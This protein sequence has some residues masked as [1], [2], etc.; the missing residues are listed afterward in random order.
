[1][2]KF[3]DQNQNAPFFYVVSLPDPHDPNLVRAPYNTMYKNISFTLPESFHYKKVKS[4]PKWRSSDPKIPDEQHILKILPSYYGMVKCIDDN[5]GRLLTQLE[6]LKLL[7]NTI[8][9]FSSDHGDMLGEHRRKNKG[10]PFEGS[11]KIPFLIHYPNGIAPG[12]VVR[13]AANATDWMETIL[14]L[15]GV[16]N[17]P[18][19]AGR[20]LIPLIK[21]PN[22]NVWDDITFL[23][24]GGW[25]AAFDSQYKLVLDTGKSTS[26]WLLDLKADPNESMN[27]I[28]SPQHKKVVRHLAKKL[29][30][31]IND[32]NDPHK[33]NTSIM[34]K[35]E[36]LIAQG[37]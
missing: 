29:Q 2:L 33:T 30:Q 15:A 36:K 22:L 34:R 13:K 23:R 18:I 3:I 4:D 17:R 11:A 20:D 5:V 27:Y 21:N 7:D 12:S 35:L 9:L 25:V 14:S 1:M 24:I 32:Q 28:N 19:T 31:Y 16:Q 37:S 10:V 6:S 26:P 8:I